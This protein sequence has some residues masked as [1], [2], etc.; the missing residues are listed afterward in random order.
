MT[1]RIGKDPPTA[2]VDVQ[3]RRADLDDLRMGLIEDGDIDVQVELLGM[4]ALWPFR[5][6]EVRH[7]LEGEHEA[8]FRVHSREA[9]VDRP[10][11]IGLVDRAAK[12]C[13][14]KPRQTEGSG[15]SRTTHCSVPIIAFTFR[16]RMLGWPPIRPW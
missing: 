2:R 10:S 11:G 3:Q 16:H 6:P 12:Q 8:G 1:R 7:P 5:C 9:I 4:G 14:V 15:Q 13:L